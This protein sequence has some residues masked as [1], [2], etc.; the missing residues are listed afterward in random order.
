[1]VESLTGLIQGDPLNSQSKEP[2]DKITEFSWL[3]KSIYNVISGDRIDRTTKLCLG[4]LGDCAN[5]YKSKKKKMV[6]CTWVKQLIVES[7]LNQGQ[8][9]NYMGN[10]ALDSIYDG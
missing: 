1:M 3:I 5:N 10:W 9:L 8:H 6:N 7:I 2:F 4:L